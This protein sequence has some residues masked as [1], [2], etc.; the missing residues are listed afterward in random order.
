MIRPTLQTERLTLR[1]F[2]LQD[3]GEVTR[4][5]GDDSV[6]RFIPAIPHPYPP[7]AAAEWISTHKGKFDDG[8]EIIFAITDKADDKL[9]GAVGLILTPEHL[10]AEIGY[11][12]GREYR[13]KDVM[14]EA[15][16]AVLEYAFNKLDIE[17][18]TAHHLRPNTA[19]GKVMQKLGM[20][21]E[22]CRRKF[23]FHRGEY[24]DVIMYGI[25]KEEFTA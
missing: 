7:K 8:K 13:G 24:I 11:W 16:R 18:V 12:L 20:K 23:Y 10:R 22:G 9:M 4:M 21:Y 6:A 15:A 5:C 17:S 19:S 3:A 1:P 14:T 2:N 25:T